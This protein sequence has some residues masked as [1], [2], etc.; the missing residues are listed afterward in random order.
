MDWLSSA[1]FGLWP[2]HWTDPYGQGV[3]YAD[4][5]DPVIC[6]SLELRLWVSP[7]QPQGLRL[8][9][10]CFPLGKEEWMVGRQSSQ[11]QNWM[12]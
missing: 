3:E 1:R 2:P 5:L 10:D 4:W 6:A 7:F 12:Q 8:A 11:K 9:D